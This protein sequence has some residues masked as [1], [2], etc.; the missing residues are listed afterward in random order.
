MNE[1]QRENLPRTAKQ[2]IEKTLAA[3]ALQ[4]IA[5]V[6]NSLLA[7]LVS[8]PRKGAELHRYMFLFLADVRAV[9]NLNLEC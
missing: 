2:V 8:L 4:R 3:A 9:L 1:V 5:V 6:G 7:R